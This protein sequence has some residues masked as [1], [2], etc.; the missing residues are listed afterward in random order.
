MASFND[1]HK[2]LKT[3]PKM[4]V[5]TPLGRPHL[6]SQLAKNVVEESHK[7][8]N[9]V[10]RWLIVFDPALT[11]DE[12]YE[13]E[14]YVENYVRPSIKGTVK[15]INGQHKNATAGHFYR[16]VGLDEAMK[17]LDKS[18]WVYQLDDD[19]IIHP[20]LFP[21]INAQY[22]VLFGRYDGIIFGQN[23]PNGAVRLIGDPE[24]VCVGHVD[25]A[26]F[27][28]RLSAIGDSRFI[29]TDYCADGHF[30]EEVFKKNGREKFFFPKE[31]LCYYNFLRPESNG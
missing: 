30:I 22:H 5:I 2:R 16:N 3:A 20:R 25:T 23:W 17:A 12:E 9:G 19:N 11:V 7:L 15:L 8:F 13:L 26:M 28:L 24:K 6:F 14:R 27:L 31:Q 10:V 18:E 4:I 21:W 29:A 1:L